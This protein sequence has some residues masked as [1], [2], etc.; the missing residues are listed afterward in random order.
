MLLLPT[1]AFAQ[2]GIAWY[3]VEQV[4]RPIAQNII[5]R[6]SIVSGAVAGTVLVAC[7]LAVLLYGFLVYTGRARAVGRE[8]F[9][10]ALK[11]AFVMTF[12]G[13]MA[14]YQPLTYPYTT[15][16][17][18]LFI[19]IQNSINYFVDILLRYL[20]FS[21]NCFIPTGTA[22][23]MVFWLRVDCAIER[24]VGYATS[25]EFYLKSGLLG[26]LLAALFSGPI[27][28]AIFMMGVSFL[29]TMLLTFAKALYIF[30]SAYVGLAILM[31]LSP[32][33]IPL[34]L[35]RSTKAMFEKWLRLLIG[36]ILQPLFLFAY[37]GMMLMVMYLAIFKG[38]YSVYRA[39]ACDAVNDD[40]FMIGNYVNNIGAI[41]EGSG[42]NAFINYSFSNN[43]YS[44]RYGVVDPGLEET[45]S[46]GK[47][48]EW[49]PHLGNI[50]DQNNTQIDV[51]TQVLNFDTLANWCG[52]PLG[53][54]VARILVAFLSAVAISYI[55]MTMLSFVPYLATELSGGVLSAPSLGQNFDPQKMASGLMKKL[56]SR[57]GGS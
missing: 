37:L 22:P 39:I 51:P 44:M 9:I 14:A 56:G 15:P 47:L 5:T 1:P 53:D 3:V 31:S 40:Y 35:F 28:F 34:I 42:T 10:L 30:I 12:S 24:L 50:Y 21:D 49:N 45:G 27:G 46:M 11:V 26:I 54:Y 36:V 57:G 23:D 33:M 8:A 55:F 48:G 4:Q 20:Y 18:A 2:A 29:M 16:M 19:D 41:H 32:L 17:G 52:I 25:G 38:E 7:T 13:A 43:S 6:I